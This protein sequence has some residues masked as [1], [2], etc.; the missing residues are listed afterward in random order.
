MLTLTAGLTQ[1][2]HGLAW[3]SQTPHDAFKHVDSSSPPP[4]R[5]AV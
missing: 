4:H 2:T 1:R 3:P 5:H